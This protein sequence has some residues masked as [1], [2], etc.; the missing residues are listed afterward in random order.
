MVE[1]INQLEREVAELSQQVKTNSDL[2]TREHHQKA[3]EETLHK[4]KA[5][6]H[7]IAQKMHAIVINAERGIAS[8]GKIDQGNKTEVENLFRTE[9]PK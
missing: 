7:D 5:H 2:A 8:L 6:V 4:L 9:A 1:N 3:T